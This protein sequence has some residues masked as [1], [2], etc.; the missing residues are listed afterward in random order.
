MMKALV[1]IT[2]ALISIIP[3]LAFAQAPD[4]LWTRQI[5]GVGYDEAWQIKQTLD[6]GL[7]LVGFREL[8]PPD[9][10]D[11]YLIKT[12]DNGDTLWTR[13]Y[14]YS[15]DGAGRSVEPLDDGGFIITG[16]TNDQCILIKTDSLGNELWHTYLEAT[17]GRAIRVTSGGDFIIAGYKT[18]PGKTYDMYI[19]KTNNTGDL[20][21]SKTY[22]GTFAEMAWDVRETPDG[23]FALVGWTTRSDGYADLYFVKTDANG[24]SI[25]SKTYGGASNSEGRSLLVKDDGG[26]IIAGKISNAKA[27]ISTDQNGDTLWTRTYPSGIVSIANSISI[28]RDGEYILTAVN[29][30]SLFSSSVIIK[31]N[32]DGDSIWSAIIEDPVRNLYLRSILQTEDGGYVAAGYHQVPDAFNDVFLVKLAPDFTGIE[33][34]IAI[35]PDRITLHQNYPNPFNASTTISFELAEPQVVNL[36]VYNL[37]GQKVEVLL[38]GKLNAGTHEVRFDA[39]SYPSGLYFYR[40]KAGEHSAT[41]TMVLL[42]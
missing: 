42:K 25:W 37:L 22:G 39:G 40:L 5:G 31:T 15:T 17:Y 36:S 18:I 24:D 12:D 4:T 6:G 8:Q 1:I 41:R 16:H 20:L 7:I 32:P 14:D 3:I 10:S 21:W 33:S 27:I 35:L 26:F 11:I 23:G 13:I 29:F 38:D 34:E 2:A 9:G 19:A 28:T 30:D